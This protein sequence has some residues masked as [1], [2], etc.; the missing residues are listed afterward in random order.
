MKNLRVFAT[1]CSVAALLAFPA[2]AQVTDTDGDG[3]ADDQD[4][5]PTVANPHQRDT[6]GDG[7][8]D[9]CDNCRLVANADQ[10]DA[11][12]DGVGDACDLCAATTADVPQADGSLRIAVN[13]DGCSISQ[14]CPCDG[15]PNLDVAWKN[16][17]QYVTCVGKHALRFVVR[18]LITRAEKPAVVSNA[19]H[20]TCGKRK[21]V[22]GVDDDGDG[23]PNA[24]DNCP[25]VSNP[26]QIDTDGDTLGNACD[27][28]KD[29]DGIAN[30]S[31]NCPLV[32]NVDQA[33]ADTDGV[34]DA[35]DQCPDTA[36]FAIV[37]R[38]GCSIDQ[39][40]PCD[41][42]RTGKNWKN[43]GDFVGCVVLEIFDLKQE[44]NVTRRQAGDLM[45]RARVSACGKQ[46]QPN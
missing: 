22:P 16:H 5:C 8:G 26:R 44:G 10:A 12:A 6:D 35:C 3:I 39:R 13:A 40:C 15:P 41:G 4:N 11:D 42:P 24:S 9:R 37:D 14:R 7:V 31:D 1:I 38:R 2:L 17:G 23:V 21:P 36:P 25:S 33:D 28:D 32:A 27:P 18:N 30:Q 46:Q 34:G 19:S 20:S 43:H 45:S 29:G